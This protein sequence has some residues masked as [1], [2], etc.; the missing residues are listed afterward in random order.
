MAI[1]DDVIERMLRTLMPGRRYSNFIDLSRNIVSTDVPACG[2]TKPWF[3][4]LERSPWHLTNYGEVPRSP[5]TRSSR[6]LVKEAFRA[7]LGISAL[8]RRLNLGRQTDLRN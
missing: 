5:L 3:P 8:A 4:L 7:A 1:A 2:G 6:T